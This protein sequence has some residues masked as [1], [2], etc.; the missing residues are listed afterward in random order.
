[1]GVIAVIAVIAGI[2]AVASPAAVQAQQ[3]VRC[4]RGD[5][6]CR[7][8]ARIVSDA[9]VRRAV[10]HIEQTDAAAVRE[11]IA[12]TQIPAPPFRESER[13]RRYAELLRAAGADSVDIDEAGN[14]LALRRGTRRTRTV[15]V[16]GH[17]DTVFPEGTDVRVHQ[18]GDTL[19]APGIADNTRG[20]ITILQILRALVYAGLRAEANLLFVGTVG[21]E[22]LGDL[23]G[24]KHLFR[25]GGQNIDAYIAVDGGS[26]DAITVGAIGSKRYRVSFGGP[27]GHSWG[28]FGNASPIHAIGRAIQKF[29]DAATRF[30][31]AFPTTT[32]NVGRIGGG[33]SV[34][35]I[36]TNAW[37]E[38]DLR[39]EDPTHLNG[40]DS[41]FHVSMV[42]AL[43]EQNE[44]RASGPE[45]TLE[46]RLVGD[47]PSGHTPSSNPIVQR[48]IAVT[49]A[50]RLTPRLDASSTDSNV[51]MSRGIP[52]IALGRG[53]VAGNTHSPEE[54]WLNEN[55]TRGIRRV[56]YTVL[57][58]GG[59]R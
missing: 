55:G 49:R 23:R 42:N 8:V 58:E 56:F 51:P 50:L 38:V 30:T 54:W 47:R 12:L 3:P 19:F 29:D 46:A 18:R 27:G 4:A 17:L 2:A 32:Y 37:A 41:L 13:A 43:N 21:E 5:I 15:A 45:L 52:A 40:I 6:Y 36:A 57:A 59:L 44:L 31:S 39:S 28:L 53:G 7:E 1:L 14:V 25:E 24:T 35:S 33:T 34:N 10:A 20:L 48:A 22:G 9:R 16:A 26:D 11:L